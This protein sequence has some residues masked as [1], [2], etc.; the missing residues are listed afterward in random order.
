MRRDK[1][2]T[3]AVPTGSATCRNS[4]RKVTMT[5]VRGLGSGGFFFSA[6]PAFA[7]CLAPRPT[8]CLRTLA[9][10]LA[11]YMLRCTLRYTLRLRVLAQ[12]ALAHALPRCILTLSLLCM[13]LVA[14]SAGEP[15]PAL[16]AAA[17]IPTPTFVEPR[18]HEP[19][20][21]VPTVTVPTVQ[22]PVVQAPPLLP[23][24]GQAKPGSPGRDGWA[25]HAASAQNTQDPAPQASPTREIMG[26]LFGG[27]TDMP[28]DNAPA[29]PQN[30]ANQ[31]SAQSQGAS[32]FGASSPANPPGASSF[33]AN[34]FGAPRA[35]WFWPRPYSCA[36]ASA[37]GSARSGGPC[38]PCAASGHA[39]PC[40]G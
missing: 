10:C 12:M 22:A 35:L 2:H 38:G 17:S 33:G 3:I 1:R 34:S 5:T 13:G 27:H 21:S 25:V 4:P 19:A 40:R 30:T 39:R 6:P 37:C 18:V 16:A 28:L 24:G 23:A 26:F 32:S 9:Q 7:A 29:V 15:R 36:A 20:V 31:P 11:Q 8:R 14:I